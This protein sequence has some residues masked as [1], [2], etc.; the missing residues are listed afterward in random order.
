MYNKGWHTY[1]LLYRSDRN[2]TEAIKCYL[3]ALRHDKDNL[4]ILRDL[5]LLQVQMR[6]LQ[7]YYDTRRKLLTL[8][9]QQGNNWLAFGMSAHLL[10]YHDEAAMIIDLYDKTKKIEDKFEYSEMLLYKNMIIEESGKYAAAL[11]HLHAVEHHVVDKLAW[12]EKRAQLLNLV[13]R[14]GDSES[15]YRTLIQNNPENQSYHKGIIAAKLA[16][17]IAGRYEQLCQNLTE[18]QISTL[19]SL[20]NELN[21][22]H[23]RS[24]FVRR[25]PLEFLHGERFRTAF[26]KYICPNLRKGV[27]SLFTGLKAL[28]T[29]KEKMAAISNFLT[30]AVDS[31]TT[32]NTFPVGEDGCK[33]TPAEKEPP[34]S[35]LWT[36]YFAAQHYDKLHDHKKA[37]E[38]IERALAHTPTVIELYT[39]K[40]KVLKHAGDPTAAWSTYEKGR[41]LDLADRYLNTKA[42]LYALRANKVDVAE[43]TIALF[44]KEGAD[45]QDVLYDMQCMWY[46]IESAASYFRTK[47]YGPCLKKLVAVDKHFA[48]I[49]EDQFDFHTYC[50]RKMTLR[51]YI[52]LLRLEDELY[53]LK[54]YVLA[55]KAIVNTYITI[56][57]HPPTSKQDDSDAKQGMSKEKKKAAK[58]AAHK[59]AKKAAAA[60]STTTATTASA[61][62]AAAK[63]TSTKPADEDPYGEK[64]SLVADPLAEAYKFLVPLLKYSPDDVEVQLLACKLNL[65]R[66]IFY[67]LPMPCL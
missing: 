46:E 39:L 24:L 27:P 3:N 43:H 48:D 58:L 30:V 60:A 33:D 62:V 22:E 28:Y 10:G 41:E 50:L 13:G 57:D 53:G 1:G 31:L 5:S 47:Q 18:E 37:I 40:A 36:L 54:F 32:A 67:D 11:E 4:Q 17:P 61:T 51:A 26:A 19:E 65:R 66:R 38:Q 23:P 12:K 20:Y 16:V 15:A 55:A 21:K 59:E 35:L 42:T 25:V 7:G 45:S 6:D 14:Y 63:P 34:S 64:L 49:V 9:P 2:Y 8:K 56:F 29:D 44:T 52:S